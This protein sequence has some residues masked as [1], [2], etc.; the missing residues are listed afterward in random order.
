MLNEGN[1]MHNFVQCVCENFC[2][3]YYGSGTVINYGSGFYF[4]TSYGY[5]SGS[6]ATTLVFTPVCSA[7]I[8]VLSWVSLNK[9]FLIRIY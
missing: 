7:T 8:T 1:R 3:L 9:K 6:G 5:G 2:D 4:L